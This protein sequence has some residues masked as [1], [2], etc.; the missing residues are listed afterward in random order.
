[1]SVHAEDKDRLR[2][3]PEASQKELDNLKKRSVFR[4]KKPASS[5]NEER[6]SGSGTRVVLGGDEGGQMLEDGESLREDGCEDELDTRD[7]EP[8]TRENEPNARGD[9][10]N[11]R[12]EGAT[13]MSCTEEGLW[14]GE[15]EEEARGGRN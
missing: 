13:D 4:E 12:W 15:E 3:Q 9:E 8:D 10:M 6:D 11:T 7:V 14:A 1:M 5:E 2:K